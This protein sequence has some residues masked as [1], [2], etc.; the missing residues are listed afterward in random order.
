MTR[1]APATG[2]FVF[3]FIATAGSTVGNPHRFALP[4]LVRIAGIVC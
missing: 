1:Q 3:D 2:L 4:L